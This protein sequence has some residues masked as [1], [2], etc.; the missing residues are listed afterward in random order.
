MRVQF[1]GTAPTLHCPRLRRSVAGTD[2][3]AEL[4]CI[5]EPTS[6]SSRG[7]LDPS[8]ACVSG[9]LLIKYHLLMILY[10]TIT[11]FSVN[12]AVHFPKNQP[13]Y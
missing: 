11:G 5:R 10:S 12:D 8:A 6:I 4:T 1:R 7:R 13:Y 2:P 3:T 9:P